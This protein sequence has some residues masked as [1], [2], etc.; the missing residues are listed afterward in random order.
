MAKQKGG[1]SAQYEQSRILQPTCAV[2]LSQPCLGKEST[3]MCSPF[4]QAHFQG[5]WNALQRQSTLGFACAWYPAS[6][7]ATLATGADACLS[8]QRESGRLPS[9]I[10]ERK[11]RMTLTTG[12]EEADS[13]CCIEIHIKLRTHYR[14]PGT[15]SNFR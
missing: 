4:M 10:V 8:H 7:A 9:L 1:R 5:Q 11:Y 12:P 6:M 2:L 14:Y 3:V 13:L 15:L